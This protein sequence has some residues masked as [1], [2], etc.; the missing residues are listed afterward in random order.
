VES[1]KLNW[2]LA[3][4]SLVLSIL[5][6]S[7]AY[8]QTVNQETLT[9]SAKVVV[10]GLPDNMT[11]TSVPATIDVRA[12]GSLAK[13]KQ[14]D[15]TQLTAVVSLSNASPGRRPYRVTLYPVHYQE[16]FQDQ[17]YTVTIVI[18]PIATRTMDVEV[19]TIGQL[20]DP[21]IVLD[22]TLVEPPS[23]TVSGPKSVV[24]QL[25]K[26]RAMLDLSTIDLANKDAQTPGVELLLPNGTVPRD[27]KLD[28]QP[29]L[30]RVQPIVAA[31]PQQK[32]VFVNPNIQGS[33]AEGFLSAG[34]EIMPNQIS[35]RGPSRSVAA[36]TQLMTDPINLTGLKQT[37]DF[38][39]NLRVPQGLAVDKRRITV[40]VIIKPI[41]TTQPPPQTP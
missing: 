21:A 14:I 39:V 27:V 16:F 22:E 29:M 34:Y 32:L 36:V 5:I 3:I 41:P 25:A 13:L 38:I 35:V 8:T 1:S 40:R 9:L 26:A 12:V 20:A 31:A 33:P 24:E 18:E 30:V 2:P 4:A 23:V 17:I 10:E 6:W 11:V 28:V 19:E 15:V 37:T 7:I